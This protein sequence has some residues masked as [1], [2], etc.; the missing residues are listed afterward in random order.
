[1][2]EQVASF[3]KQKCYNKYKY[4]FICWELGNKLNH[5][6]N[7]IQSSSTLWRS[8]ETWDFLIFYGEF[9]VVCNFFRHCNWL[10][11]V[12]NHLLFTFYCDYFCIT[13]RL[14]LE[15]ICILVCN[16]YIVLVRRLWKVEKVCLICYY[17]HCN[18][19]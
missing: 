3:L 5:M 15:K 17:L 16:L 10:L 4:I 11:G 1:M 9:V 8:T 14:K 18:Y 2:I 12:N 19:G 7:L 6:L 13:I